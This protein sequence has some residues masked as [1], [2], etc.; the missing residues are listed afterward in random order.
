MFSFDFVQPSDRGLPI[1]NENQGGLMFVRIS[2]YTVMTFAVSIALFSSVRPVQGVNDP[3]SK[4][5]V[6]EWGTF[7]TVVDESGVEQ[8][9]NPLL[10]PTELPRFIYQGARNL[11]L[12][13]VAECGL[14]LARMETPVLYFYADQQMDVSVKVGFPNGRISEWYPVALSAGAGIDWGRVTIRPGAA[15]KFR[16]DGSKS[17]YY[18]AR[19]TD[20]APVQIVRG[21]SVETEKFLFY[22]GLG[23]FTLPLSVKLRGDQ[24]VLESVN[25]QPISRVFL[26]E[27]RD[28]RVGW[29][30]LQNVC[31]RVELRR[32]VVNQPI[33]SLRNE[34][35]RALIA[36]GL[37][38][39]EAAAMVK[40]WRDAWFEEGLRVLLMVPRTST[41]EIIPLT[42]T[43]APDELTR[44]MV[45]RT[46]ILTPEMKK[47]VAAALEQ[48]VR[49]SAEERKAAITLVRRY[50]RFA[51]PLLR[52]GR[53]SQ[54]GI[55]GNDIQN[56]RDA[57]VR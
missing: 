31:D 51:D 10:G 18:P 47:T 35:E 52:S 8:R 43:P 56:F 14:T 50:G 53:P 17:H 21:Q 30:S 44:V 24:V 45:G 27:N 46:E 20:A 16:T 57:A 40:T 4:Y 2:L 36:E 49:G 19:E 12:K 1:I 28:G 11:K 39:K 34:M 22:R 54:Q 5:V 13:C 32:P 37:Y 9:W 15:E 55:T 29:Q 38:P 6:H 26:V 48:Y 7:T 33:E 3:S 42:L 25:G 41:D 23:D